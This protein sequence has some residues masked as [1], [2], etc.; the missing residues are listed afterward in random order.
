LHFA[1]T[2]ILGG[3]IL[4]KL[5]KIV[6]LGLL[7]C[8][9]ITIF[10]TGCNRNSLGKGGKQVTLKWVLG[11]NDYKDSEKVFEEYNKKL[12]EKMPNMKIEFDVIPY[13]DFAEKWKLM[14]A[15]GEKVD[16]VWNGFVFPSYESEIKKGSFLPLDDLLNK[17]APELYKEFPQWVWDK[18]KCNGEIYSV[19]NYQSMISMP[20][21]IRTSKE[22]SDKYLDYGKA[23]EILQQS[24]IDPLRAQKEW[25]DYFETYLSKLKANGEIGKGVSKT[26][27]S[28]S[29]L[30]KLIYEP[31]IANVSMNKKTG[32][33][34]NTLNL[35]ISNNQIELARKWYEKGYIRQDILGLQDWRSDEGKKGGYVLWGHEYFDGVEE[36]ESIRYGFPVKVIKM[37]NSMYATHRPSATNTSIAKTCDE[38]Q[39]AIEFLQL[40]NT[41]KGKELYNLLVFGIEGQ[42]YNKVSDNR[43]EVLSKTGSVGSNSIYGLDKY[44]LGNTFYA[45]ETQKDKSG[46]NKTMDELN[47]NA[48][49]SPLIGFNADIEAIKVE[50]SQYNTIVKEYEQLNT[51]ALPNYKELI[52]QR[53]NKL[54]T[55]GSDKIYEEVKKQVEEWR[56]KHKK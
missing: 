30:S 18:A 38:P 49:I 32:E 35:D 1:I 45:Y 56:A 16:L 29:D 46:Y 43:I 6:A 15:S 50:V 25:V 8:L 7:S 40:M 23:N 5:V 27:F 24:D 3:F 37:F 21:G 48:I 4:Y 47:K 19:P 39:K 53:K 17:Y 31:I 10:V 28:Y 14:A 20:T 2:K 13:T 36:S 51:G 26:F 42:H 54:V 22:L 44:V 33:I 11:G 34:V 55:A 52:E 9:I 12:S 41:E